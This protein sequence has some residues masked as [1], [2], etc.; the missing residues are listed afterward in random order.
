MLG[1]KYNNLVLIDFRVEGTVIYHGLNLVQSQHLLSCLV[2]E[3]FC[4]R[5]LFE[6]P[7]EAKKFQASSKHHTEHFEIFTIKQ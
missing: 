5:Q 4:H 2:F 7:A 3:Y 6:Y 1:G